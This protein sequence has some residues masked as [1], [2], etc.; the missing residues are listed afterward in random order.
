MSEYSVCSICQEGLDTNLTYQL[1]CD[2]LIHESCM[3]EYLVANK[4]ATRFVRKKS[5]GKLI[6]ETLGEF[7]CPVCRNKQNVLISE[8][9]EDSEINNIEDKTIAKIIIAK[10]IIEK[11]FDEIWIEYPSQI[12]KIGHE[13]KNII[14]TFDIINQLFKAEGVLTLH[15]TRSGFVLH[16]DKLDKRKLFHTTLNDFYRLFSQ[17][18][19]EC[20]SDD[21]SFISLSD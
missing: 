17:P 20:T 15:L 9:V 14:T 1:R 6:S 18:Y 19:R 5:N 11:T 21:D 8:K 3:S 16:G 12:L 7:K 4:K 13:N 10:N 2:H